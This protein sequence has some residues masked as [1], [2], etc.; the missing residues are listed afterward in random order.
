M[1]IGCKLSRLVTKGEKNPDNN[2]IGE[3]K[4]EVSP[5]PRPYF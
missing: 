4:R 3:L 1:R 5:S 2:E